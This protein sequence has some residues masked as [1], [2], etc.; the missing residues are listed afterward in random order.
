MAH[1][2]TL[3][4]LKFKSDGFEDCRFQ[5]YEKSGDKYGY[6]GLLVGYL[7]RNRI[8]YCISYHDFELVLKEF[9]PEYN[10]EF[11]GQFR[12]ININ[13]FNTV[14][15]SIAL[16]EII[17]ATQINDDYNSIV[18]RDDFLYDIKKSIYNYKKYGLSPLKY[19]Y[20]ILTYSPDDIVFYLEDNIGDIFINIAE[21]GNGEKDDVYY[22]NFICDLDLYTLMNTIPKYYIKITPLN[23]S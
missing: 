7:I 5:S 15:D 20:R 3:R 23:P 9:K 19:S 12:L 22:V 4:V 17:R 1:L 13:A 10:V 11:L 8:L 21:Y 14:E 18:I 2:S 6:T 16:A